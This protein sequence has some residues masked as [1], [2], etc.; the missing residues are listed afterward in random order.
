MRG[1]R[2]LGVADDGA[3]A[4]TTVAGVVLIIGAITSILPLCIGV[5]VRHSVAAAADAAALAA[6]DAA[7]GA[8][9]GDPCER[10]QEAALI[11]R[12]ELTRCEVNASTASATV[13]A[14]RHYFGLEIVVRARA[15]P[16]QTPKPVQS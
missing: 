13:T 8:V 15:E 11:N 4:V 14:R 6:S 10:A 3:I 16:R 5:A 1:A 7:M 12:A 2:V 9:P